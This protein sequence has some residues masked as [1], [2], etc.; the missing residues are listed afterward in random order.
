MPTVFIILMIFLITLLAYNFC[1]LYQ[2]PRAQHR[3][4]ML[5]LNVMGF[6]CS[7]VILIIGTVHY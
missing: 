1:Y 2:L 4:T 5:L 7:L 3:K 6:L